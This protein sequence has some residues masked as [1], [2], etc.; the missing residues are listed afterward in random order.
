[1]FVVRI[2][3]YIVWKLSSAA[4]IFCGLSYKYET[5]LPSLDGISNKTVS[6]H[7]FDKVVNVVIREVECEMDFRHNLRVKF[8]I[9]F[10]YYIFN[11]L[12]EI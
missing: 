10:I 8:F 7:K 4:V 12:I 2:K 3:Y 5:P 1:M 11:E 9:N 6:L